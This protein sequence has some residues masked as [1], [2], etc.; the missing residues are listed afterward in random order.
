MNI[1]KS[2]LL[3]FLFLLVSATGQNPAQAPPAQPKGMVA[4]KMDNGD[5]DPEEVYLVA[6]T[7]DSVAFKFNE[8]DAQP[9]IKKRAE[10]DSIFLYDPADY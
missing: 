10:V 8:G 2:S 6:V 7:K 9:E 1:I 3:L 4:L 5:L